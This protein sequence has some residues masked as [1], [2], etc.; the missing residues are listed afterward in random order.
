MLH[1]RSEAGKRRRKLVLYSAPLLALALLFTVYYIATASPTARVDFTVPVAI[2]L[3]R[4]DGNYQPVLPKLVGVR[5]GIWNYHQYDSEGLNGHYPVFAQGTPNGNT[6]YFLLHV[7]STVDR[8]YT[9]LDFFNVWGYPLDRT[10]TLNFTVPPPT[11]Q[12]SIYGSD[13]YWDMCVQV[14]GGR[15]HEGNWTSQPLVPGGSI[16]LRYS[17]DGCRPIT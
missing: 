6:S 5:G 17:G 2:Q 11:S 13:W 1:R 3:V 9:L 15:I 14:N 12:N 4:L 8:T 16:V 10:N 7:R